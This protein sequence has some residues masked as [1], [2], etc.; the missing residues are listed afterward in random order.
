MTMIRLY[1]K[2]N[3]TLVEVGYATV[4]FPCGE[5]N[6][7]L[8]EP[9]EVIYIDFESSH[10]MIKAMLIYDAN[11]RM[12]PDMKQVCVIPYF[13]ASRQDRSDNYESFGASVYASMLARFDKIVTV[14]AHSDVVPALFPAGQL[15]NIS[16]EKVLSET[17]INIGNNYLDQKVAIIIPD[18]G[19][20]KKATKVF[21]AVV[22]SSPEGKYS[23]LQ[24]TKSR[25]TKTGALSNITVPA[26]CADFS[27]FIIVDD[28][29]DNGGT[30]I[31]LAKAIRQVSPDAIINL[32]VSHARLGN[33]MLSGIDNIYAYNM[34]TISHNEPD[35]T[36]IS[37]KLTKQA[38]EHGVD[39]LSATAYR[40]TVKPAVM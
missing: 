8:T 38:F 12:N 4:K 39:I 29:C 17:V 40:L 10:D 3:A 23:L 1:K 5:L 35:R 13:P 24:A 7:K 16:Q 20:G 9:A 21:N 15:I 14:D 28:I 32:V 19:A 36:M 30:F 6:I 18:A 22:K 34:L 26:E 25:D 37:T 2:T 31:G 33:G 27:K 11:K